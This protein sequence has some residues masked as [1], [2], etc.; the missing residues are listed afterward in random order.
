MSC[1]IDCKVTKD[2]IWIF[3]HNS[4]LRFVLLF[5]LIIQTDVMYLDFKK[6]FDSVAHNELLVSLGTLGNG[7]ED[8]SLLGFSA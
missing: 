5:S 4:R 6:A 3:Q 8:I 1:N 7:L 2:I